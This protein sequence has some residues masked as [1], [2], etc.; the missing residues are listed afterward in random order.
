[1]FLCRACAVELNTTTECLHNTAA[2]RAI[3][4]TWVMDEVRMPVQKG[5]RVLQV[6]EVYEYRT[7]QYDPQNGA[8]YL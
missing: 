6:Y 4:G 5:N 3:T 1:M 7:T 2:E 8:A